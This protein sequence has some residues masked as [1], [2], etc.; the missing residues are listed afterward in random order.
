MFGK[1]GCLPMQP[2]GVSQ[3]T[4]VHPIIAWRSAIWKSRII[5]TS[6]ETRKARGAGK[7]SL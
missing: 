1:S 5:C 7:D 6:S 4:G 3:E 2:V